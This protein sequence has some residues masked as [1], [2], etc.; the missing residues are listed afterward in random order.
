MNWLALIVII[1]FSLLGFV[2]VLGGFPGAIVAF[3]G[4]FIAAWIGGFEVMG[5]RILAV[6]FIA[7]A[8]G[9]GFDVLSSY[10]GAKKSGAS[11]RTAVGAMVG[12]VTGAVLLSSI[13]PGMGTLIGLLM[14]TFTGAFISEYVSGKSMSDSGKVGWGAAVAKAA[15]VAFKLLVIISLSAL[16]VSRI[17][18]GL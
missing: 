5:I 6:F 7:A 8:A 16:A 1:I 4:I 13:F 18:F 14:G 10:W 17:I 2:M 9:E 12:G 11:T 3:A 15:A